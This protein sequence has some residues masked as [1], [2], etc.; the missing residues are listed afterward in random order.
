MADQSESFEAILE[1]LQGLVQRLEKGDLSLE[2]SLSTFEDGV[3]L[4]RV[5]GER[6]DEAERRVEVLLK[7]SSVQEFVAPDAK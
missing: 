6:L 2:L 1:K 5:A 3:R 4:A 7:D